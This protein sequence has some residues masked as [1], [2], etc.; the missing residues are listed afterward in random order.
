MPI[1]FHPEKAA[2]VWGESLAAGKAKRDP[3]LGS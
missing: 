2:D 1:F 3:E